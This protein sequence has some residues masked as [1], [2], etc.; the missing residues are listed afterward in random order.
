MSDTCNTMLYEICPICNGTGKLP[1][2]PTRA[3][4]A[5]RFGKIPQTF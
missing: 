1:E 2:A 3:A 4:I 5:R